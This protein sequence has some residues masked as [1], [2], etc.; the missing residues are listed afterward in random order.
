MPFPPGRRRSPRWSRSCRRPCRTTGSA[1]WGRSGPGRAEEAVAD[2]EVRGQRIGGTASP[3]PGNTWRRPAGAHEAVVAPA[4]VGQVARVPAL[5]RVAPSWHTW[6]RG[7]NAGAARARLPGVGGRV[8]RPEARR[9]AAAPSPGGQHPED[10]V[11]RMVLH[12]QH[13]DVLDLRHVRVPSGRRGYGSAPGPRPC[14]AL[15]GRPRPRGQ[16]AGAEPQPAAAP[17]PTLSSDR[18]ES[19]GVMRR[20]LNRRRERLRARGPL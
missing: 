7:W 1:G 14:A 13:D 12:H 20:I 8:R 2:G 17:P 4:G 19:S 11:E 18:R 5:V 16:A 9:R 10:A 6:A 15:R 3:G